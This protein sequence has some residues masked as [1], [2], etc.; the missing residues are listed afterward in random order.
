MSHMHEELEVGQHLDQ[1]LR[2]AVTSL[3]QLMERMSRSATDK[4]RAAAA[5]ERD[6]AQALAGQQ[7]QSEAQQRSEQLDSKR[8]AERAWLDQR[9]AA[10]HAY[11][12]WTRD[13]AV[14]RGDRLSASRAWA[15]AAGWAEQDPRAAEAAANLHDRIVSAFGVEPAAILASVETGT[16]HPT[17]VPAGRMSVREAADL[18]DKYAPHYYTAH[19]ADRLGPI[20][21]GG[22][23]NPVQEKFVA[24]WRHWAQHCDLPRD[25]LM[26]EWAR[27]TGLADLLDDAR[28]A[29]EPA[30]Q[31]RALADVWDADAP[32][33]EQQEYQAQQQ[34]LAA[35]GLPD[36]P[37]VGTQLVAGDRSYL[38]TG[39]IPTT[40]QPRLAQAWRSAAY[41]AAVD[42][43][44]QAAAAAQE[45]IA[46][47]FQRRW[48]ID[49]ATYLA[50]AVHD[51]AVT[52]TDRTRQA[53]HDARVAAQTGQLQSGA[54][55]ISSAATAVV[56]EGEL[57]VLPANK[58][59]PDRGVS[60][61]KAATDEE[62]QHRQQAWVQAFET[63][64]GSEPG[65]AFAQ[66]ESASAW[67]ALDIKDRWPLFW[68]E[69][70]TE[71]ARTVRTPNAEAFVAA[72]RGTLPGAVADPA[73]QLQQKP[74]ATVVEEERE[75]QTTQ[76]SPVA[77]TE[78]PV[79]DRGAA[80]SK[81]ATAAE[82]DH[83]ARSWQL[84]EARYRDGLD[85]S[86]TPEQAGKAWAELPTSERYQRY[87]AVYDEPTAQ[88]TPGPQNAQ[89][90]EP[91]T[92]APLD[93]PTAAAA[94]A[95]LE[96]VSRERVL[97][98]NESAAVFY[99]DQ[100]R[101]GTAGHEYIADRVGEQAITSGQWR[102]GYAPGEWT[103]LARHLRD[104][105]GATD[106]E[107]VAAGLGR[108][109]SRGN[110]IDAFRNRAMA[111]ITDTDGS[112]VGF[113]GRDLTGEDRN[114]K[115]LNT[116]ST[117]AY[118]KGEHVFGLHEAT[119]GGRL[120]RAEA[121]FDAIALT[122]ASD[123]QLQGIAPLGTALTDAQAD[124]IAAAARTRE[125]RRVWV[126]TDNDAGG[127]RQVETDFWKF[128]GRGLDVREIGLAAG[129]DPAQ[130]WQ[131]SPEKLTALVSYPDLANSAALGVMDT[132]IGRERDALTVGD[133]DAFERL[134]VVEHELSSMVATDLDRD[135]L[136]THV[137][138][139]LDRLRTRETDT[140]TRSGQVLDQLDA[141][142]EQEDAHDAPQVQDGE[143]EQQLRDQQAEL[144]EEA[145]TAYGQEQLAQSE[146]ANDAVAAETEV[147]V[148][149]NR[150]AASDLSQVSP[151]AARAR[152]VS[153]HGFSRS[154]Q[155]ALDDTHAAG[156]QW[157]PRRGS[158]QDQQNSRT[159]GM[160]R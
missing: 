123:G 133:A 30:E 106:A 147:V 144:R 50:D 93:E 112:V 19:H 33:R 104:Q 39:E 150:A 109:S 1:A 127:R 55:E 116:G 89:T 78:A 73:P 68:K 97:E 103:G 21:G 141:T 36:D 90:S 131:E 143:R 35:A 156:K 61:T 29:G 128:T 92:T 77:T 57:V 43:S 121:M 24:D 98:L 120:V 71:R 15:R 74:A 152:A 139:E 34:R 48:N 101:P 108:V 155:A 23:A 51:L 11:G 16:G 4:N 82:R 102:L 115:H 129:A 12:P 122:E 148:P 95:E 59:N 3:A 14:E 52:G 20:R 125:D 42:P 85:P 62:R 114:P 132:T 32:T 119:S 75:D 113:Y 118:S 124:K 44:D 86:M 45:N 63:F 105:V 126:A 65:D 130:M 40:D 111:A 96:A 46:S 27:H 158:G 135:L 140:S 64:M 37:A 142:R 149:Y 2:T 69:Y 31:G 84:A 28:F 22:P 67:N 60:P 66:A 79:A 49:P 83:R 94:P 88:E 81:A 58:A 54:E 107:I 153:A 9:D 159:K 53:D 134:D 47:M 117:P 160:R 154:T 25:T 26:R 87:W 99:A 13:T 146:L 145:S 91:L 110:V 157:Q 137:Q 136:R 100:L 10:R 8:A 70:D 6:R 38:R 17:G 5:A 56:D 41:A 7:R 76:Q 80:P 18:A 151:Q 72:G 138:A